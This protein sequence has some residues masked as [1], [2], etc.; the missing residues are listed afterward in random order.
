MEKDRKYNVVLGI[1]ILLFLIIIGIAV[2]WGLGVIGLREN[3][4]GVNDNIVEDS[5]DV[6]VEDKE[7]QEISSIEETVLKEYIEK[8]YRRF[9][10]SIPEF[11][12]INE[13]EERWLWGVIYNNCDHGEIW[14]ENS[15]VEFVY[16]SDM[17]KTAEELFGENLI[18]E[19]PITEGNINFFEYSSKDDCYLNIGRGGESIIPRYI[20]AQIDR[21]NDIFIVQI[22]E[23]LYDNSEFP[24]S[25][26]PY[27]ISLNVGE[28]KV[29]TFDSNEK[30]DVEKYVLE[31]KDKFVQKKLTIKNNSGK[32]NLVSSEIVK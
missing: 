19:P 5:I 14:V 9:E 12:D 18:I 29:V 16:R 28:S 10:I 6:N 4:E 27:K 24:Y 7:E 32:Y 31:N 15:T 1:M 26:E 25:S 3:N 17:I 30:F 2:A 11:T 13:A 22:V 21:K 8:I 20:I 23:Y